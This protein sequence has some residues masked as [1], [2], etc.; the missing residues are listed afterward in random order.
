MAVELGSDA[1]GSKADA[2]ENGA[3]AAGND[4]GAVENGADA[5]GK[6]AGVQGSE[7]AAAGGGSA[8]V[9]GKDFNTFACDTEGTGADATEGNGGSEAL[10]TTGK[11]EWDGGSISGTTGPPAG[12]KGA[13]D[14]GAFRFVVSRGE[15]NDGCAAFL[16]G[17][18]DPVPDLSADADA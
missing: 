10:S 14:N 12:V 7:R 8:D 16:T 3:E 17:W 9:A 4:E 6:D 1:V 2:V 13:D 11:A 5:A 15:G 18:I